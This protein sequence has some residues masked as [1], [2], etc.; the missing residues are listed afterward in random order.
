MIRLFHTFN[1]EIKF[2]ILLPLIT[3]S[4]IS[5]VLVWF[6]FYLLRLF[7]GITVYCTVS[8]FIQN[9][10]TQHDYANQLR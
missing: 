1:K 2:W 5:L 6:L 10:I 7:F 8:K 4:Y 9:L 3:F